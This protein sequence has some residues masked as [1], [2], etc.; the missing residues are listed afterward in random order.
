MIP[1]ITPQVEA[2]APVA[3]ASGALPK[4]L[5]DSGFNLDNM[6]V[7]EHLE[8]TNDIFE[9]DV[10]DKVNEI[11][12]YLKSTEKQIDMV[13]LELGNP[14]NMTKLDKIYSYVQLEK[15][16]ADIKKKELLIN[17][18]KEQYD[19]FKRINVSRTA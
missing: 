8:L 2:P 11:S 1:T 10:M 13:D 19:T 6:S 4:E 5:M 16:S 3:K 7:I 12:E 15:Q 9:S 17:N 14:H 18:E